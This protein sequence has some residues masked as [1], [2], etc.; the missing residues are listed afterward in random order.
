MIDTGSSKN[1]R[2]RLHG[3]W[4]KLVKFI[5]RDFLRKI[6]PKFGSNFLVSISTYNY[7]HDLALS[8]YEGRD[9]EH[10]LLRA[11]W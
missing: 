11:E 5:K 10:C 8:S 7:H 2:E 4:E 3:K 9:W 1:S 6:S